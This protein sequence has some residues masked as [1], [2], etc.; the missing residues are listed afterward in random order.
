MAMNENL[1]GTPARLGRDELIGA[2]AVTKTDIHALL[3]GTLETNS[4]VTERDIH[5][6][7]MIEADGKSATSAR[8]ISAS[9]LGAY[10]GRMSDTYV[11][12]AY[13]TSNKVRGFIRTEAGEKAAALGGNFIDLS[14]ASSKATG[15]IIGSHYASRLLPNGKETMDSI[16][17]RL[18][19]LAN[20]NTM[21]NG[22]WA[23]SR[24]IYAACQDSGVNERAAYTHIKNLMEAGLV[25]YRFR[26]NPRAGVIHEVRV[27]Q[28]SEE[29]DY[30]PSRIIRE[31]LGI[32]GGF[33]VQDPHLIEKGLKH[34]GQTV[35]DKLW[36]PALIQRTYNQSGHK[37]KAATKKKK[38]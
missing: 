9:D 6:T 34:V 8:T 38:A 17:A 33:I 3:I 23:R 30:N 31:F 21:A 24:K 26:P 37:V 27:P 16:E 18:V 5:R 15:A 19:V 10:L 28:D 12:T 36:V 35:H 14:Q 4:L 22:R 1:T 20:L 32:V 25:Q 2:M 7:L 29:W 11:I 13:S